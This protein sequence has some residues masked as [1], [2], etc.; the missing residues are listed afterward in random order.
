MQGKNMI[1]RL[2]CFIFYDNI[3]LSDHATDCGL[4]FIIEKN[5]IVEI[6]YWLFFLY[7]IV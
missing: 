3:K 4:P 7:N 1:V 5:N 2:E 6:Q